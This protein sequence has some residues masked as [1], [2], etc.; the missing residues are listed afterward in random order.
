MNQANTP[1]SSRPAAPLPATPSIASLPSLAHSLSSFP[2]MTVVTND[3]VHYGTLVRTKDASDK[4][5]SALLLTRQRQR[6][7][8]SAK[9]NVSNITLL[10]SQCSVA[11][12]PYHSFIHSSIVL[13]SR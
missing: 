9:P 7:G 4:L 10:A 1:S 11:S 5:N 3:M 12:R 8:A 13:W 2:T 6:Q